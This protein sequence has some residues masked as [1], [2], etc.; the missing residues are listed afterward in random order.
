MSSLINNGA[1]VLIS[2]VLSKRYGLHIC[3]VCTD[4]LYLVHIHVLYYV[5]FCCNHLWVVSITYIVGLL[6]RGGVSDSSEFWC[7]NTDSIIS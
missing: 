1:E 6:G 2:K 3:C 7:K 4:R 5:E